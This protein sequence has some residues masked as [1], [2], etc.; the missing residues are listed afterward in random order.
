MCT[1]SM[2][3]TTLGT[4]HAQRRTIP[5]TKHMGVLAEAT[6]GLQ[7]VQTTHFCDVHIGQCGQ[8]LLDAF[9]GNGELQR[10]EKVPGLSSLRTYSRPPPPPTP[11]WR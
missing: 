9:L 4:T 1:N 5:R 7:H 2:T 10:R 6:K 8:K 3:Y 11:V